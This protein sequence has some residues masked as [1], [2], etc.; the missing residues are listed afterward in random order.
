VTT[1]D[2]SE[3][4]TRP[5]PTS[6][7]NVFAGLVALLGLITVFQGTMAGVFVRDDKERDARSSFIDAHAWG[8]HIG[9]V[10]A[11]ALA[12]FAI[13]KLRER[14]ELVGA[15]VAL[16]VAFLGESYIGGLIRD[17]DKQSLTPIHVPLGMII[18]GLIVFLAVKASHLRRGNA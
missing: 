7:A 10:L 14:R 3:T 18:L 12:A 16:A 6:T 15:S 8:A 13:W 1:V 11:V 5:A 4:L 2:K 17:N 9:T